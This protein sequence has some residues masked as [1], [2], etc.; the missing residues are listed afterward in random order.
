M[1]EIYVSLVGELV[2]VR[3]PVQAEH[4]LDDIYR[5]ADQNCDREV[6][7][8][9]FEPGDEVVCDLIDSADGR[10]RAATRRSD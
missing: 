10:I 1:T 9:Q 5:I 4:L 3:R 8:W 6:E 2:D 7:E